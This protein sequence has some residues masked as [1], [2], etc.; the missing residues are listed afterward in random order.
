MSVILRLAQSQYGNNCNSLCQYPKK[1]KA[2]VAFHYVLIDDL[3][4]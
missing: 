3:T 2:N 1:Q 4:S